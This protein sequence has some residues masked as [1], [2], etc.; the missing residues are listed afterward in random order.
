[1]LTIYLEKPLLQEVYVRGI[2][3]FVNESL[4]YEEKEIHPVWIESNKIKLFAAP[5]IQGKW[6]I[7]LKSW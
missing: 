6:D 2:N 4:M 3:L 1:M 7:R 5:L